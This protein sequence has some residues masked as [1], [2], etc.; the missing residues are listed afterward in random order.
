MDNS[1]LNNPL[2]SPGQLRDR[3]LLLLLAPRDRPLLLLLL[4][5]RDRL[6]PH[7]LR[8]NSKLVARTV[9]EIPLFFPVA[10]H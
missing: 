4:A 1:L 6:R 8:D 9:V 7:L 3:P 10:S 5:P 2:R